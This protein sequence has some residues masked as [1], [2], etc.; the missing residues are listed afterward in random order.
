MKPKQVALRTGTGLIV[1]LTAFMRKSTI[2]VSYRPGK[3]IPERLAG[4]L[5]RADDNK[6]SNQSSTLH[7]SSL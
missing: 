3:C 1:A 6:Y 5:K 7:L 2:I 4:T